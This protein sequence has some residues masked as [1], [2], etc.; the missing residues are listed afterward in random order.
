MA[1]GRRAILDVLVPGDVAGID[2]LV[3]VHVNRTLRGMR[4][5][6]LVLV[7]RQVVTIVD[8]AGLRPRCA[9]CPS[10]PRCLSR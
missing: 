1:D 7:D 9:D 10:R 2:H 6:R 8:L 3:L 5:E 4:E